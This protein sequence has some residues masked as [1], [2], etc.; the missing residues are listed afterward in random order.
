MGQCSILSIAQSAARDLFILQQKGF[1]GVELH[2]PYRQICHI[3]GLALTSPKPKSTPSD[4]KEPWEKAKKLSTKIFD[5][6][7]MLYFYKPSEMQELLEDERR[8]I[9]VT[10][11]TF[12]QYLG[13]PPM[14]SE[15]QWKERLQALYVPFDDL[16]EQKLGFSASDLNRLQDY[17]SAELQGQ[18]DNLQSSH[19][20]AE[21]CHK[22]FVAEFGDKNW[23]MEQFRTEVKKPY[24]A[25]PILDYTESMQNLWML[26]KE[27]LN[28]KF[29][30]DLLNRMLATLGTKRELEPGA[31]KYVTDHSPAVRYP[32]L[33]I[34]EDTLFCASHSLIYQAADLHFDELLS[35]GKSR[36]KFFETRDK[37][38]ENRIEKSL[39]SYLGKKARIWKGIC[40]TPDGQFEHDLLAKVGET[41]IV[42]EIKASPLRRKFFDPDKAY[43]RIRDDFRSDRGIQ[44]AYEQGDR[45]KQILISSEHIRLYDSNRSLVI[46]EPGPA[47]EVFE[48]CV[49]GE[50]W[51]LVGID[52][53]LLLE[54]QKDA[55]YPWAVCIDDL[56]TF[57]N[58]LKYRNKCIDNIFSF[59]RQREKL[60]GRTFCDDELNICGYFLEHDEL[61]SI[62]NDPKKRF[63][64]TPDNSSVFD[65]IF[66]K[67]HGVPI[68]RNRD[69]EL[70]KF[71]SGVQKI[72][73]QI[74]H[75]LGVPLSPGLA[76]KDS[77]IFQ[78][79]RRKIGRNEP[80]PCG[81]G[82]KYK[83]CCGR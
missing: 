39:C 81:A 8:K 56:E 77:V 37:W 45:L 27:D 19:R 2:S 54:K 1:G 65:E 58:G 63:I 14:R 18:L 48:I 9:E 6:Y 11:C 21:D 16:I 49:T 79:P 36:V 25:D 24:I 29:G 32:L 34:E 52:L 15:D 5:Q 62:P 71:L 68:E 38:M 4:S 26:R 30:S 23:T 82:R 72:T 51:G 42:A 22:Q 64:F 33:I 76:T 80:C 43:K 60:H 69:Q 78:P 41:W 7:V 67:E 12:L 66:F 46:D 10:M 70:Q 3:L 31:Y 20:R 74:A 83:K 50:F 55:P 28:K 61:P 47:K 73:G 57:L 35:S 17:V 59:F 53:S 44:K 75:N 40:E 13:A